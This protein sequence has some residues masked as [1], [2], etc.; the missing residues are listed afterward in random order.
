MRAEG[1]LG[2][3]ATDGRVRGGEAKTWELGEGG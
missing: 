1:G 3:G 2:S